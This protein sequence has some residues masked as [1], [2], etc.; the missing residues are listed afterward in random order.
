MFLQIVTILTLFH[1]AHARVEALPCLE[2]K[3]E[4]E[5]SKLKNIT[6]ETFVSKTYT[7]KVG[8]RKAV[9]EEIYKKLET[10]ELSEAILKFPS[11]REIKVK[12]I[13]GRGKVNAIFDIGD[14]KALRVSFEHGQS[15]LL[16]EAH[17]FESGY[18]LLQEATEFPL[19]HL[20]EVDKAN[21]IV[22]VEN[23]KLS[24]HFKSPDKVDLKIKTF[25]DWMEI[26]QKDPTAI[27]PDVQKLLKDKLKEFGEKSIPL[28]SLDDFHDENLVF[29]TEHGWMYIDIR[30]IDGSL[31]KAPSE[32]TQTV[33]TKRTEYINWRKQIPEI[34]EL[35]KDIEFDIN[36]ERRINGN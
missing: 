2:K 28:E 22:I 25:K 23:I 36:F 15:E 18:N 12:G 35:F 24:I 27:P 26:L 13:L 8:D 3:R 21:D 14:G 6:D 29:S 20:Y 7:L 30:N 33:F 5:L 9:L 34:D 10:G 16:T 32:S 1:T 17:A 31:K 11:G 19:P 4:F